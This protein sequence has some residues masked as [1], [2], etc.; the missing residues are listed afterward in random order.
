MSISACFLTDYF[1]VIIYS[2]FKFYIKQQ[3]NISSTGWCFLFDIIHSV[4][5][6]VSGKRQVPFIAF[7]LYNSIV[8]YWLFTC[9][10]RES[11]ILVI[12]SL[13]SNH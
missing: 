9:R 1:L 5:R 2:I 6:E 13:D 10:G 7:F 4:K 11:W 3:L 12:K 8:D